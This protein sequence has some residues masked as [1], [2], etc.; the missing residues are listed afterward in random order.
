MG[1][2]D[3][4]ENLWRNSPHAKLTLMKIRWAFCIPAWRLSITMK[5]THHTTPQ[6]FFAGKSG[7]GDSINV[8]GGWAA[9]HRDADGVVTLVQRGVKDEAI[10][11]AKALLVEYSSAQ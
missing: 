9:W 2:L 1:S 6:E 7:W 3:R 10:A 11:E 4:Q 8:G 5:S